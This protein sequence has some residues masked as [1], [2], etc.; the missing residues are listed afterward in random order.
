MSTPLPRTAPPL[1]PF[2]LLP[3]QIP[4]LKNNTRKLE[5]DRRRRRMTEDSLRLPI[6][7]IQ[8]RKTSTHILLTAFE[9]QK[10]VPLS[11]YQLIDALVSLR[12]TMPNSTS[13]TAR[14]LLVFLVTVHAFGFCTSFLHPITSIY[15]APINHRQAYNLPNYRPLFSK[16]DERD[17]DVKVGSTEYYAGFLSRDLS[18][19]E[20]RIAGDKVLIP[21]L[22]FAGLCTILIGVSLVGFLASNGLI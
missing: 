20:E 7:N 17:E 8:H 21:A 6:H 22:K 12:G 5:I 13:K 19:G 18:E 9:I 11:L 14:Q 15:K 2:P 3:T 1:H 16:N 4:S 10:E